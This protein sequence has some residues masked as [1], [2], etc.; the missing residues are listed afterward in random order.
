MAPASPLNGDLSRADIS[1]E[2]ENVLGNLRMNQG[3]EMNSKLMSAAGAACVFAVTGIAHAQGATQG[4]QPSTQPA[5]Q[6]NADAPAQL[7]VD[8][9]YGGVPATRNAAGYMRPS[10]CTPKRECD[11][12]F[13]H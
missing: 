3:T 2:P 8:T 4:A 9:S 13:G 11:V 10:S 5:M 12:D 7:G 1:K 6:Q